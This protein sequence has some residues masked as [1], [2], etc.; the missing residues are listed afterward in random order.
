MGIQDLKLNLNIKLIQI[1]DFVSN[2]RFFCENRNIRKILKTEIF[3]IF[4]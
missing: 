3:K 1:W 2:F 4:Y